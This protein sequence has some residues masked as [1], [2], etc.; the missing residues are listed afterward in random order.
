MKRIL[1]ILIACFLAAVLFSGCGKTMDDDEITTAAEVTT[2]AA[3]TATQAPVT[4]TEVTTT[5]VETTA[6]QS[7]RVKTEGGLFDKETF[8]IYND[9]T[10]HIKT[11]TKT[12]AGVVVMDVYVKGKQMASEM[13]V[14]GTPMR[15]VFKDGMAYVIMD[16][17]KMVMKS[18]ADPSITAAVGAPNRDAMKYI[19]NGKADFAG[20]NLDYEEYAD[21]ETRTFYFAEDGELKGVRTVDSKKTLDMEILALDK[22]VPDSVFVI[23]SDYMVMG[24]P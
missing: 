13:E 24:S 23:P 2:T 12:D 19:G 11:R 15:T 18:E 14:A 21:G 16:A 10:Y 7:T 20:R 4:T 3:E 1:A 5:T 9:G 6:K 17:A 8:D 22:K